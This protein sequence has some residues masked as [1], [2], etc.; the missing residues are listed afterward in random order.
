L[1]VS[2]KGRRVKGSVHIV[3]DRPA[4]GLV[5]PRPSERWASLG[6][7]PHDHHLVGGLAL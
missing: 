7:S 4:A 6:R 2:V 5:A 3:V 1:E